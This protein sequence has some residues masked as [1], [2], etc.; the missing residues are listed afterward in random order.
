[1]DKY[2]CILRDSYLILYRL[3]ATMTNVFDKP[4]VLIVGGGEFGSTTAVELLQSGNYSSVTIL[5]R[6]VTLPA[7][8]A[9]STDINKVVRF[10]YADNDYAKLACEAVRRWN[11]PQWK[12]VYFQ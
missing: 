4:S 12:G 1:M 2:D 9:A 10:D 7:S 3:F 6:A 11:Q 8:D 5:D